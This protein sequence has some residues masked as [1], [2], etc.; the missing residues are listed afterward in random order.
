MKSFSQGRWLVGFWLA[1][2]ALAWPS[3]AQHPT[4]PAETRP[5]LQKT[6]PQPVPPPRAVPVR[7]FAYSMRHLQ[8]VDV[9]D[10]VR[11]LLSAR[12]S[13][14]VQPGANSLVIR[15][16]DE[17]IVAIARSLDAID[18]PPSQI[19]FDIRV[20]RA[21]PKRPN[22]ISPPEVEPAP[23]EE[24]LAR[25]LRDLL[26]YDEFRV[27]AQAGMSSTEGQRV[28]YALGEG[29]DV[30]FKLG[31]I[32]GNQRVKLETFRISQKPARQTDKSRQLAPRQL[33]EATLN[34]W[35]GKTFTLVLD[36]DKSRQEALMI[37][38]SCER[39]TLAK[40]QTP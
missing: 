8:A 16:I 12:G 18:Q 3:A 35:L 19:R 26:R 22:V 25:R 40:P 24:D 34:L 39:E 10:R 31:S 1:G 38:I 37:A 33:F 23:L 36:Q 7:V 9:L 14:E 2:V 30:S 13:V 4:A 32:I 5:T 29:Y 15:D 21:G 6:V 27:L 20:V 28:D 11:P 17:N